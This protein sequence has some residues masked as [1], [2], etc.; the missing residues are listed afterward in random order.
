MGIVNTNKTEKTLQF[1][2]L[3]AIKGGLGRLAAKIQSEFTIFTGKFSKNIH[4]EKLADPLRRPITRIFSKIIGTYEKQAPIAPLFKDAELPKIGNPEAEKIAIHNDSLLRTVENVIAKPVGQD[5][6]SFFAQTHGP[7]DHKKPLD[8]L[9]ELPEFAQSKELLEAIKKGVTHQ[10]TLQKIIENNS[11]QELEALAKKCSD[12]TINLASGKSIFLPFTLKNDTNIGRKQITQVL[13]SVEKSLSGIGDQFSSVEKEVT[14]CAKKQKDT[15]KNQGMRI[16]PESWCTSIEKSV[17]QDIQ[18]L[19]I[20]SCSHVQ[21]EEAAERLWQSLVEHGLT[22]TID[23]TIQS[24]LR[25]QLT[26]IESTSTKTIDQL[27]ANIPSEAKTLLGEYGYPINDAHGWIELTKQENN[28]LRVSIYTKAS[29]LD[30]PGPIP[31]V[32]ENVPVDAFD[33]EQFYRLFSYQAWPAWKKANSFTFTDFSQGFL[34]ALQVPP[35]LSRDEDEQKHALFAETTSSPSS[36]LFALIGAKMSNTPQLLQFQLQKKALLDAWAAKERGKPLLDLGMRLLTNAKKLHTQHAISDTELRRVDATYVELT[37]SITAEKQKN[38]LQDIA[39]ALPVLREVLVEVFGEDIGKNFDAVVKD[40]PKDPLRA[41]TTSSPSLASTFIS[42]IQKFRLSPYHVMRLLVDSFRIIYDPVLGSILSLTINA[43]LMLVIPG[44][45][46]LNPTFYAFVGKMV[47]QF[48]LK[49]LYQILPVEMRQ[50]LDAVYGVISDVKDHIIKRLKIN[51]LK[52]VVHFVVDKN[53]LNKALL[54]VQS[55]QQWF[56]KNGELSFALSGHSVKRQDF[57]F[58]PIQIPF[59]KGGTLQGLFTAPQEPV[60]NPATIHEEI[61]KWLETCPSFNSLKHEYLVKLIRSLP[62]PASSAA[63]PFWDGLQNSQETIKSLSALASELVESYKLLWHPR[64]GS[65]AA[66]DQEAVQLVSLHAL[67]SMIDYLARKDPESRLRPELQSNPCYL[68]EWTSSFIAQVPDSK[69]YNQLQDIARYFDFDIHTRY[70]KAEIDARRTNCLFTEKPPEVGWKEYLLPFTSSWMIDAS[71]STIVKLHEHPNSPDYRYYKGLLEE[72]TED[73]F[74]QVVAQYINEQNLPPSFRALR[75]I[76]H[77]ATFRPHQGPKTL[78]KI[79]RPFMQGKHAVIKTGANWNGGHVICERNF[80]SLV[81][82]LNPTANLIATSDAYKFIKAPG[83]HSQMATIIRVQEEVSSKEP[84]VFANRMTAQE[85]MNLEMATLH[86]ADMVVR[87]LAFFAHAP[88]KLEELPF[89]E[90]FSHCLLNV[91]AMQKQ[92]EEEPTFTTHITAFFERAF[93]NPIL[94]R[95]TEAYQALVELALRLN[96]LHGVCPTIKE[97]L[98][99]LIAN[100]P[101]PKLINTLVYSYHGIDVLALPDQERKQAL[102]DILLYQQVVQLPATHQT[103]EA[104]YQ[105]YFGYSSSSSRTLF[106]SISTATNCLVRSGSIPSSDETSLFYKE[107][108]V[109]YIKATGDIY[110]EIKGKSY[111]LVSA[112]ELGKHA[113]WLDRKT[114]TLIATEG[115]KLVETLTVTKTADGCY[116]KTNPEAPVDLKNATH[117]LSLLSWMLPLTEIEA[118]C[119]YENPEKISRIKLARYDLTFV[120]KV[121]NGKEEMTLVDKYHNYFIRRNQVHP[122]LTNIPQY[123]LL[124]NAK[125]ELL[126]LIPNQ[127]GVTSIATYLASSLAG[128]KTPHVVSR[129][130]EEHSENKTHQYFAFS[131]NRKGELETNDP[132]SISNRIVDF[133]N[134]NDPTECK[135]WL[136]RLDDIAKT[137]SLPEKVFTDCQ[138]ALVP[139]LAMPD[140]EWIGIGLKLTAILRANSLLPQQEKKAP[141]SKTFLKDFIDFG[142]GT[143]IYWTL[144]QLGYTTYLE[145]LDRGAERVLDAHE[146]LT[147]LQ[148]LGKIS[149]DLVREAFPTNSKALDAIFDPQGMLE[150]LAMCPSLVHRYHKIKQ[151]LGEKITLREACNYFLF[152]GFTPLPHEKSTLESA[153][154]TIQSSVD[155]VTSLFT[156]KGKPIIDKEFAA[157]VARVGM[158][159]LSEHRSAN[160]TRNFTHISLNKILLRHCPTIKEDIASIKPTIR[161]NFTMQLALQA[162]AY[163]CLASGICPT[164]LSHEEQERFRAKS[165]EFKRQLNHLHGEFSAKENQLIALFQGI[166]N[167]SKPVAP[168]VARLEEFWRRSDYT[169]DNVA[170]TKEEIELA[171]AAGD[172]V[173]SVRE[174]V[175]DGFRK[176]LIHPELVQHAKSKAS[177]WV[178]QGPVKVLQD[179]AHYASYIYNPFTI[180]KYSRW[181]YKAL[182]SIRKVVDA[183]NTVSALQTQTPTALGSNYS[184]SQIKKSIQ[185]REDKLST[186]FDHM[187][188]EY[189]DVS[190]TKEES[191]ELPVKEYTTTKN[192]ASIKRAFERLNESVKDFYNRPQDAKTVIRLK[193]D[194]DPQELA[195]Q[196]EQVKQQISLYTKSLVQDVERFV[197]DQLNSGKKPH[198]IKRAMTFKEIE[199]LFIKGKEKTLFPNNPEHLLL[200]QEKLYLYQVTN[201]KA[202]GLYSATSVDAIGNALARKRVY[203]FD[204]EQDEKWLRAKL[205]FESRSGNFLWKKPMQQLKKMLFSGHKKQ[206]LELIMASGKNYY[207]IPTS[208]YMLADGEH[209]VFNIFPPALAAAFIQNS[210]KQSRLMFDQQTASSKFTRDKGWT[211]DSARAF[212][213]A[214]NATR[215][216]QGHFDMTPVDAQACELKFI[217]LALAR[218][219]DSVLAHLKESLKLMRKR[220][221]ALPDEAHD[222]FYCRK[223]LNYPLGAPKTLDTSYTALINEV[224]FHLAKLPIPLKKGTWHKIDEA[225]YLEKIQPIL[226]RELCKWQELG[227]SPDQYEECIAHITGKLDY[228]PDFPHKAEI[229]LL[230]GMLTKLLP[231]ILGKIIDVDFCDSKDPQEDFA[232]PSSAN[233]A[234]QSASVIQNPFEA[235]AKTC[236]LRLR[237]RI[238]TSKMASFL[239]SL[240]KS[241]EEERLKRKINYLA[242]ASAKVFHSFGLGISL[243]KVTSQNFSDIVDKMVES[244]RAVLEYTQAKINPKIR[245]YPR[246]ISSNA[247]NFASM[248]SGFYADTGSPYNPGSF[249]QGTEVIW[250]KGTLGETIDILRRKC[251]DPKSI[252]V[253]STDDP[254]QALDEILHSFEPHDRVI[255]DHGPVFRGIPNIEIAKRMLEFITAHRSDIHGVAFFHNDKEMILEKGSSTPI[256]LQ[257]STIPKEERFTYFD[258][259][260]TFG[261]NIPQG[262]NAGIVATYGENSI[263]ALF[264]QTIWRMRGLKNANQ[265]I[266]IATTRPVVNAMHID[267]STP[268]I[269]DI[270]TFLQEN[271]G[272]ISENNDYDSDKHKL[273]DIVRRS[274]LDKALDAP[275]LD[276]TCDVACAYMDFLAPK[277][278]DDPSVL[279]GMVDAVVDSSQAMNLYKDELARVVSTDHVLDELE[280]FPLGTYPAKVPL[281]TSD[282]GL[283]M[284]VEQNQD[285][286]VALHQNINQDVHQ[287]Q[288]VSEQYGSVVEPA[289]IPWPEDLDPT[290][291]AS[292]PSLTSLQDV[293]QEAYLPSVEAIATHISQ[294]LFVSPNF[295][296]VTP[297]FGPFQKPIFEILIVKKGDEQ[298]LILLDQKEANY[299]RNLLENERQKD[300][301]FDPTVQIALYDVALGAVVSSGKTPMNKLD[302]L[303]QRLLVMLKFLNG[304]VHYSESERTLI[305]R[306]I[307]KCGLKKM[308]SAFMDLYELHKTDPFEASDIDI[309]FKT[310]A[311]KNQ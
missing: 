274:I 291:L 61:N 286:E 277:L 126:V 218:K 115:S 134:K 47:V 97:R 21:G 259:D 295:C 179:I 234:P 303:F 229:D 147:L 299:W 162:P 42:H 174:H 209:V 108:G 118:Y 35:N 226:A 77:L 1:L 242:T 243:D 58:I 26:S 195:Y 288:V 119:A 24:A 63:N 255:G 177:S 185:E 113:Y 216:N 220:G 69:T 230:K 194:K 130:I 311:Q 120:S 183:T 81:R 270:I 82:T 159:G 222:A 142:D 168:L 190:E 44:Y 94:K 214:L 13:K 239:S 29:L 25:E 309:T 160:T 74:E 122:A 202:E 121:I 180:I 68:M 267:K 66:T 38:P 181:A 236:L 249:P 100:N 52:A 292:W 129:L 50:Y 156:I 281:A 15:L 65:I 85:K 184:N 145:Q 182:W 102:A 298:K 247:Q 166:A 4:I 70:T 219:T 106:D 83:K 224:C 256:L 283:E 34:A 213:N 86:K 237:R 187:L 252:K 73:E 46:F 186:L 141:F 148:E 246:K 275:S 241:A 8:Y 228:I 172:L 296:S 178:K 92:I 53:V 197:N 37:M 302:M 127:S 27:V 111:Q 163:F 158:M 11:E 62:I 91:G 14:E 173:T 45:V 161:T 189:F 89:R 124:E 93:E 10:E 167:S 215:Q 59:Y 276:E 9:E 95:N 48:G 36:Q 20:D 90:F 265:T 272:N 206:V 171:H 139:L 196:L 307:E 31:L 233:M 310:I 253:L 72:D 79:E 245:Y 16:F 153:L 33:P 54:N 279:Y 125:G 273:H 144:L 199:N 284:Q 261:A 301:V 198:Q 151:E 2:P 201:S 212:Y 266:K 258:Q 157:K 23:R 84:Q 6:I 238:P 271:E 285:Q 135:K 264:A 87:I 257:D 117:G 104:I 109:R 290:N 28:T 262:D 268:N 7:V 137:E 116:Q 232:K 154:D 308:K 123:L 300:E 43:I 56:T 51:C 32:F 55:F 304:T 170:K 132:S 67:Y 231:H 22:G 110:L 140:V 149:S 205:A 40:L 204:E 280:A 306:W 76:A 80:D 96:T 235:Y 175:R 251:S 305:S 297:S 240:Q 217:E 138:L 105:R 221:I 227:L 133:I 165:L 146:E 18:E 176:P 19:F 88:E 75:S 39:Q 287:D 71:Y 250:D 155:T 49:I 263:M 114:N 101:L 57:A 152:L 107:N 3:Q 17:A 30:L 254:L 211:A 5:A 278:E 78:K 169:P 208:D 112:R 103:A 200:L 191:D 203:R 12:D 60:I 192:K 98:R 225:E 294:E 150:Q 41:S 164:G 248:F 193:P 99:A 289:F 223:E 131:I 260:H 143:L 269:D 207:A 136:Q 210:S 282:L 293:L 188:T 64:D 244:D 128:I